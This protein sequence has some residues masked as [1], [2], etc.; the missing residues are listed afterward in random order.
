MPKGFLSLFEKG[1]V[2]SLYVS[3]GKGLKELWVESLKKFSFWRES[4]L[5]FNKYHQNEKIRLGW[6]T[7]LMKN[8]SIW[9]YFE[10]YRTNKTEDCGK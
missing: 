10:N 1:V 8:G 2:R 3:I 6:W 5:Y 7:F 4:I 9:K